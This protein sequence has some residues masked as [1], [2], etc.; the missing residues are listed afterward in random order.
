MIVIADTSPI[1]YLILIDQ[2]DILPRLFQTVLIPNEVFVELTD[3][4]APHSVR[5]W[6]K[7]PPEWLELCPVDPAKSP[8]IPELDLGEEAAIRLA[9]QQ[10][11]ATLLLMDDLK[12]RGVATRMG[13]QTTGTLGVLLAA[14]REGLL[15]LQNVL[16][17]LL[18]TNFYITP[19]LLRQVLESERH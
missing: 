12:G 19:V 7:Q 13:L 16:P 17:R 18:Q 6:A 8:S 3:D 1:H 2:I 15:S 10:Q 9:Q 4:V 11:S 14:S 5:E